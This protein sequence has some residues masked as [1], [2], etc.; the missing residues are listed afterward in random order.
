VDTQED[1]LMLKSVMASEII[2]LRSH[3][4]QL[5]CDRQRLI[6]ELNNF[7]PEPTVDDIR[8][9]ITQLLENDHEKESA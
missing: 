5:L 8:K 7:R 6:E 9:S 3:V 4:S 1:S 2:R